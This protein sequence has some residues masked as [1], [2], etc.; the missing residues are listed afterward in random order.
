MARIL[1]IDDESSILESYRMALGGLHEITVAGGGADGLD[2]LQQGGI[3][4]VLLDISMPGQSGIE[5]L[6][7]IRRRECDCAVIMV[8]VH[9][10]VEMVVEAMK[11][12]ADDYLTKPFK[13]AELRHAVERNLKVVHLARRTRSLET[14]LAESV[15]PTEEI[16]YTSQVMEE[17]FDTLRR[18]AATDASVLITGESGTGKEL[19]AQFVH[20]QSQRAEETLVTVNCAAIPENLLESELFGHEKGA[21]SGAV[22]RKVGKFERANRGTIFLDEI[23]TLPLDLQSKLLRA[24]EN[25]VIE[26]LGG[27]VPIHLDVRWIAATNRDLIR[28]VEQ[29]VFREDLYYRLNVITVTLPPLR[30]RTGDILPLTRHFLKVLARDLKRAPLKLQDEVLQVFRSYLWPGNVRELRNLLERW[31]VLEPGP[32]IGVGSLPERMFGLPSERGGTVP[33][34][35][36][37]AGYKEAIEAFRRD[38]IVQ[39]MRNAG[40][41]QVQAAR[42]LGLHRNTLLHH[43]RNLAIRPEEWG[44]AS[45]P[46]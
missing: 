31:S 33:G 8:T 46:V 42:R 45:G 29:G 22:E 41:N 34:R 9:R 5:V 21:F 44:A 17:A 14:T 36:T 12:G 4:V 6:R 11:A 2:R 38:L 32:E 26:R 18:A 19:A 39:A 20:R 24:L 15:G 27:H 16:V 30:E 43:L 3:D 35:G 25:R 23:A 10:D 7:E 40:G 1:A 28:L 37:P 13:V